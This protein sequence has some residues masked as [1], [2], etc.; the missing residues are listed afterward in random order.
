MKNFAGTNKITGDTT[1]LGTFVGLTSTGAITATGQTI[2]IGAITSTGTSAFQILNV[3]Q[4][5]NTVLAPFTVKNFAGTTKIAGD[6][7]G[8]ITLTASNADIISSG[9]LFLDAASGSAVNL[10]VGGSAT[11][12]TVQTT[13]VGVGATATPKHALSQYNTTPNLAFTSTTKNLNISTAAQVIDT[14]AIE[15]NY[16][17]NTKKPYMNFIGPD[18]V[19]T[20]GVDSSGAT[21]IGGG[22]AIAKVVN[23][24]RTYDC[25]EIA[26]GGDSTFSVTSTGAVAG[27]SVFVGV[28]VAAEA[29]LIITGECTSNDVVTVRIS[30]HFL[31]AAVDPATRIYKVTVVNF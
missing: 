31:V 25:G 29:G 20:F 17:S 4:G 15:L 26:A 5:Q 22:T 13:L 30:N 10:R 28:S 18:G 9:N 2:S 7:T 27:N 14:S 16:T 8:N 3:G 6:T 12:L 11:A 21:T 1:G 23:A 24:T 19:K